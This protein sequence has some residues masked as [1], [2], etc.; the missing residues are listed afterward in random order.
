M[1]GVVD[2]EPSKNEEEDAD[3]HLRIDKVHISSS[4]SSYKER[5]GLIRKIVMR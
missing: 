4:S 5:G 2:V 1:V 3:Q